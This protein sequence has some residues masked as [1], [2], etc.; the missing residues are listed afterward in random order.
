[1]QLVGPTNDMAVCCAFCTSSRRML[2]MV[3]VC[4]YVHLDT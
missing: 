4:V 2:F 3:H 1:M